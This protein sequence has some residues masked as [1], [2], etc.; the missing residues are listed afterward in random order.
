MPRDGQRTFE[1]IQKQ[2]IYQA[3]PWEATRAIFG[4]EGGSVFDRN[5]R[6]RIEIDR[7][8]RF[9]GCILELRGCILGLDLD[10]PRGNPP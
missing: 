8:G 4:G 9:P 5:G 10:L 3:F 2:R 7:A 6:S 1:G